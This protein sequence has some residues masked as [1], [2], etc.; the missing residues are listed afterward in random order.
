MISPLQ[1]GDLG[2]AVGRDDDEPIHAG[3]GPCFDQ[4]RRIID[5]DGRR[6]PAEYL[7]SESRL[8]S[9][10][11]RVDDGVQ[12][13]EAAPVAK[14]GAR[15]LAAVECVVRTKDAPPERV[16]NLPPGGLA[17]VDDDTREDV[18]IDECG[19]AARKELG[20]RALS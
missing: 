1:A 14:D 19:S 8:L 18:G 20:H 9:G 2:S 4:D 15:Q 7:P 6:T 17:A 13:L 3:V 5:H 12:L 16:H 10:D 11:T